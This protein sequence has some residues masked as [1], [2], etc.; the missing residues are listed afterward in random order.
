MRFWVGSHNAMSQISQRIRNG[1]DPGAASL[2][3][4][5][6]G[7]YWLLTLPREAWC[8]PETCPA[9]V[10]YLKGQAEVGETTG[11][12]HWQVLAV[13]VRKSSLRQVKLVFGEACHAELTR[14]DAADA[15]V[16]KEETAVSDTRF[17]LGEKP[18]RRNVAADWDRVWDMAVAGKLLDIDSSIRVQHYRTLRSISADYSK[19][20]AMV[21]TCVVLW[22]ATGTGKSRSAWEQAGVDAYPKDPRTKFWCGYQGQRNGIFI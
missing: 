3:C 1:V 10:A 12:E 16:W 14:S 7:R 2:T 19:P 9:G 15:Y 5:R 8:V 11:Y 21:R 20:I 17:E 22:G 18:L 4:R 13:F 6:Q